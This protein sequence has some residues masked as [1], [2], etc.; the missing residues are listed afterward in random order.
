M[1]G[2]AGGF[3]HEQKMILFYKKTYGSDG[4]SVREEILGREEVLE[5]MPE[6]AI[7]RKEERKGTHSKANP[8]A[9]PKKSK[10]NPE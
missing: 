2:V 3:C 5:F 7:H 6:P 9:N 4:I 10:R 8:K 1:I